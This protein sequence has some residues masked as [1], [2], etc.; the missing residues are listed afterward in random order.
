MK[1]F[2]T[3]WL[4]RQPRLTGRTTGTTDRYESFYER[5]LAS[6]H[7]FTVANVEVDKSVKVDYCISVI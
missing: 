4:D 5:I 1:Y 7:E 3:Y 2:A 6:C